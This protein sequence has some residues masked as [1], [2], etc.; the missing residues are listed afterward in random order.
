VREQFVVELEH[1][2]VDGL[3][4][5]NSLFSSW[6]ESVYHRQVHSETA[7][8]PMERFLSAGA[9]RLPSPEQLKEAFLWGE[10]R[11]VTK[12]A[13]IA[14]WTNRYEVD[15]ALVG[16][17]VEL[18]FD[19]FDLSDIRVRFQGREMGKAVPRRIGRHVHPHAKEEPGPKPPRASGI[20]YLA[21]VEARR[22]NELAR[23]IDYKDLPASDEH[24]ENDIGEEEAR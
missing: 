15:A 24:A 12:T 13:E 19:P 14:L 3:D 11:R 23:R 4:K 16:E 1:A 22:K 9:P 8:A 7:E 10:R 21:L 5:L 18:V 20:D 2:D 17:Q 6:V